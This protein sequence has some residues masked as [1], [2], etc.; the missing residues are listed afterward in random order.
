[1]NKAAKI[2]IALVCVAVLAGAVVMLSKKDSNSK[3][4]QTNTTSSSSAGSDTTSGDSG[5]EDSDVAMVITYDGTSFS[6]SANSIKA[7]QSVKVVN[8]SSVSLDFDSDPHPVHT[9]N[10]ELNAGDIEP[11]ESKTFIIDKKGTWGYH[12]HLN[13]SQNGEII[14]E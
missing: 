9:D 2:V 1:M 3:D 10:T 14:V 6:E 5:S 7:G 4:N 13:A 12:N 8:N 11:G